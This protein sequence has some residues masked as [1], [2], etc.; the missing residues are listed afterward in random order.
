MVGV[1][2]ISVERVFPLILGANIGTTFDSVLAALAQEPN[3]IRVALTVALVQVYF[4][5]MGVIIFYPIPFMRH[6]VMDTGKW[7]GKQT[8]Q[9]RW[10]AIVYILFLFA[11][12]PLFCVGLSMAGA[13]VLLSIL[14]PLAMVATFIGLINALQ[15]QKP[16]WLPVMFR[17]WDW[18][19]EPLHSLEPY[20]KYVSKISCRCCK[21]FK[22][23]KMNKVQPA[24]ENDMKPVEV[25]SVKSK[26]TD[27]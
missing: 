3:S 14:I 2:L 9:Y 27:L 1:G 6:M 18:L 7:L 23:V 5:V 11:I 19:P 16:T 13:D 20:D 10:F 12:L 24:Q 15:T 8:C 21:R 26:S 22:K 25:I 4:N 17:T